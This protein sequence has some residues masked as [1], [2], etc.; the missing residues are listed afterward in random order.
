MINF[1]EVLTDLK[2]DM[3]LNE[4]HAELIRQEKVWIKRQINNPE[5]ATKMLA[6]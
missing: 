6:Y 3:S 4:I 2:P 5:K 1:Y